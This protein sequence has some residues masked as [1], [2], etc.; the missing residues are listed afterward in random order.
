MSGEKIIECVPNFSEGKDED[1]IEQISQAIKSVESV[2]LLDVDM[3]ADTNR[4]VITFIAKSEYVGDAA[5]QGIKKASELIDM[6]MHRGAHPRM[7]ATDVCPFIP[8]AN[9]SMDECIDIAT[10]L[11]KRVGEELEIPIFLYENAAINEERKN[12]ANIRNGEYEGFDKKLKE[13]RWNPDF[14]PNQLSKKAGVTAIGAREFL[15]AYNINLNTSDRT[16]ANEI[17]YELRERGRWKRINQKDS[18]YYK[19]DVVNFT[20]D[21]YPDGNSEYVAKSLDD[22]EKKILLLTENIDLDYLEILYRKNFFYG[23]P[24]EKVYL[25][26]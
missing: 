23:K 9:T 8:V 11:G 18:F 20:K 17:A 26:R 1:I 6:R 15:I 4:T 25:N 3:G 7:G 16:Y 14:G 12:L 19:G 22:I 2:E 5:Y 13:K 24:N 21:Y 10:Q